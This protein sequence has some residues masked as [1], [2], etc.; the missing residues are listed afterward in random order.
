MTSMSPA[1]VNKVTHALQAVES[2]SALLDEETAALKASDFDAFKAMQDEKILRAE[3]YQ[4]AIL[5]FEEDIDI[6]Q[7]LD[8]DLKQKLHAAHARFNSAADAN[9]NILLASKNVSERIVDMIIEAARRTVNE[10]PNYGASGT[11]GLSE[12]IPVHLKINEVL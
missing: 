2:F 12:K 5:T 8:S 7:T 11:Q 3:A 6:L 1:L 10:G 9:Q 4:A